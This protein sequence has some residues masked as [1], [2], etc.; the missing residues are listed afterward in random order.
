MRV[1]KS[2]LSAL[3]L[4]VAALMCAPPVSAEPSGLV[5]RWM[6]TGQNRG[7]A[8]VS[9][10]DY[11]ADGR[12]I[13]NQQI[14]MSPGNVL[15]GGGGGEWR[16]EGNVLYDTKTEGRVDRFVRDGLEVPPT[17]PEYQ[18]AAAGSVANL[19]A[20]TYGPIDLQGD[21]LRVGFYTCSRQRSPN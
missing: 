14:T 5:G 6:C 2:P 1:T 7:L 20:T 21:T 12:Y 15:E 3:A 4:V 18:Q 13:A 17:D 16:L 10:F 11:R 8:F 9:H 19:G